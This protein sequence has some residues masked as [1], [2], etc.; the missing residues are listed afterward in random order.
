QFQKILRVEHGGMNEVLGD[1]YALTG[2]DK[3]LKLAERFC[4][5]A[6][7][8]PLSQSHDSLNGLHSNTQIPKIIGF[9][10]LYVLTG[11]DRYLTAA[12]FFWHTVV[13]KRSFATGGNGDNEHFFPPADF[14]RHLN[15]AKTMETCCS[16]NMLKLT[17]ALFAVEPSVQYA[18]YY[19]RTL[20]NTILASQD[21]DSG[22]MTYFQPTRP[23]YLKIYCTPTESF[24][25]CTGTGMENHA[26]YGDS[27]Y[28]KGRDALY[29]NLFIPSTA[30]W[31]D[32][33]L[34]ITQTTKFPEEGKTKL[35]I[36]AASPVEMAIN[37]RHPSWCA[38]AAVKVNGS[39]VAKSDKPGTY[40]EIKRTW[41]TGDLVEVDLPMALSTEA[42]PGSTDRVA[43]VYGPIVLVGALGHE[44]ITP[45]AD[46]VINERTI[47]TMMNE[48]VDVPTLG[49]EPSKILEKIEP[50][51]GESL[52]FRTV[53]LGHPQEVTLVPYYRIAHERYNMYWK[54]ETAV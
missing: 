3:Y 34:M 19:E 11:E 12:R 35:E 7:L 47:G 17:R 44:G 5:R 16:H 53:G 49:G 32:K 36:T 27:I 9:H 13:E 38:G 29:V 43:V 48:A 14:E 50:V 8:D 22:M 42:L 24:W 52:A 54:I 46:L 45:G 18:D 4:H 37:I 39:D 20:Y 23:G 33:G 40:I 31:K 21:P 28:F 26:K 41:K 51:P 30:S 2:N 6:V 1:V 25:C 10:R 15:S